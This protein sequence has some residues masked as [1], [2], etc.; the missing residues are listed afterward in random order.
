[1]DGIGGFSVYGLIDRYEAA[2]RE[3]LLPIGL[4][5]SCVLKNDKAVDE[6]VSINDVEYDQVTLLAQLRK[7]QDDTIQN[8]QTEV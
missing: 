3:N 6:P 5:D 4:S 2:A 8:A 7:L 1:I